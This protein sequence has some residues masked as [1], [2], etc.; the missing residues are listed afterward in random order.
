MIGY[1]Y[2]EQNRLI[3]QPVYVGKIIIG[4][5]YFKIDSIKE[6]AVIRNTIGSSLWKAIDQ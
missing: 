3:K 6:F 1:N 2:T 5:N 4:Y